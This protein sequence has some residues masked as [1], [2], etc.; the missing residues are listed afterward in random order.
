MKTTCSANR[1]SIAEWSFQYLRRQAQT[2]RERMIQGK[3]QRDFLHETA[4]SHSRPH[5]SQSKDMSHTAV[6]D[7]S[8]DDND[9]DDWHSVD[10][11]TSVLDA[12]DILAFRASSQ[13][14]RGRFIVY[15]GGVRFVQSLT[16]KE[17]WTRTFLELAEMR[18]VRGSFVSKLTMKPREQLELKFIGGETVLLEGMKDQNE[19]FNAVIGFS[20][21]Q[22]QA[23]QPLQA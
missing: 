15:S 16:K 20:S 23:L 5:N 9:D 6:A 7:S 10:S 18:K 8:T 14:K 21:L 17:L 1:D 11:S 13:N 12:S 3:V 19:A 22:W 4:H 2:G